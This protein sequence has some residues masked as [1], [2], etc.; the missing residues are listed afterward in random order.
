MRGGVDLATD[1]GLEPVVTVGDVPTVRN[2]IGLSATPVRYDLPPP[3]LDEHGGEIRRE[4][5]FRGM[6][7]DEG[8]STN[9]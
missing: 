1:L 9:D 7:T 4:L 8:T 5:G 6:S 3:E 2:P